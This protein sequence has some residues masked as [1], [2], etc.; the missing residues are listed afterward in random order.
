MQTH[1]PDYLPVFQNDNI[2][3]QS[4]AIIQEKFEEHQDELFCRFTD[5]YI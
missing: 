2:L 5:Y 3:K 4:A 1:F